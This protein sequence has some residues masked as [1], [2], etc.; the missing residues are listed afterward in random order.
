[1]SATLAATD[2]AQLEREDR[3]HLLHPQHYAPDHQHPLILDRGEGVWLTD[4]Q[5]RR[6]LDGLSSLWNVAVGHGRVELA[7]AAREQLERMAFGSAYIGFSNEPAIRLAGKVLELCYPKMAG[8]FFTNSGAESNEGAFKTARFYWN[9]KGRPSKVKLIARQRAYHGTTLAAA[10]MTGLPPFWKYFGPL[11]SEIVR[12]TRPEGLSCDCTPNAD[13]ECACWIEA[14]IEREGA[15]TVAAVI[16][17]PVKGAGGVLTPSDE[18]FLKLRQICDKHEVLLIADEV[19]TGFGR[20]GHWFALQRWGVE[21]DIVSFAKAITSAYIPL[22]GFIVSDRIMEVLQDLPADAPFM[23]AHT[24][25][26]HPGACAVGLRNLRIFEDEGLVENA[27]AMGE[28]LAEGLRAR[29][30][31]HP[32]VVNLRH[33][34]LMAGLTL[35]RDRGS[36]EPYAPSEG[37]GAGVV[38]HM[39]DEGG[40][41]T[42][43]VGDHLCLAPPLVANG[44]EVDLLVDSVDGA[45]RATT[46]D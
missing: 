25:S 6:Y 29:L 39:R 41:I 45:V 46:G 27:R 38:R 4:V 2:I 23:H 34:G 36:G 8:V 32:H 21:P 24:N 26:G 31:G 12:A 40:V 13:G 18:Y 10:A 7:E 3:A 5:G 20:T 35:V 30:E 11:P 1:M 37:V 44:D 42:R 19:I 14:A 15:E 16:C 28:R 17:E 22:G 9:V 33:L 43:A